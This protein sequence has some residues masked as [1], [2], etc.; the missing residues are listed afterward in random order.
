VRKAALDY[1]DKANHVVGETELPQSEWAN[2]RPRAI[3]VGLYY[4]EE[5]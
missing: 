1:L 3:G 5:D 2:A 4:Y